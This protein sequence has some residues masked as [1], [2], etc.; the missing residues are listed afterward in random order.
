MELLFCANLRANHFGELDR[1]VE[2]IKTAKSVAD[3]HSLKQIQ[4]GPNLMFTLQNEWLI[5][6]ENRSFMCLGTIIPCFKTLSFSSTYLQ[7]NDAIVFTIVPFSEISLLENSSQL[8][9][10]PF[11][12][13]FS[14]KIST[15]NCRKKKHVFE[16]KMAFR[17][18]VNGKEN[19]TFYVAKIEAFDSQ[20]K[21]L[22][23]NFHLWGFINEFPAEQWEFIANYDFIKFWQEYEDSL[24]NRN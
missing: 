14:V 22:T 6:A 11:V 15:E 9:S 23:T 7:P 10:S 8:D 3:R 2:H 12:T 1:A 5:R 16:R 21:K 13:S 4:I 17:N 20:G 18:S 24:K 19:E